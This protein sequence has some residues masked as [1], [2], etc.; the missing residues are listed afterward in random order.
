MLIPS[1]VCLPAAV[2]NCGGTVTLLAKPVL[3]KHSKSERTCIIPT[4][5]LHFAFVLKYP[6]HAVQPKL[7]TSS[8]LL[9][10]ALRPARL[11]AV[12]C[13]CS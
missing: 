8:F 11:G 2:S 5:K 6:A 7:T 3:P 12:L 1:R 10:G 4:S 9:T 13:L